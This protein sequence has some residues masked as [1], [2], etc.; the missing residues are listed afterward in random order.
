MADKFLLVP[1]TGGV[2]FRFVL[3]GQPSGYA[4]GLLS[5]HV[6]GDDA[7]TAELSCEHPDAGA[8][9]WAPTRTSLS[10]RGNL[11]PNT[12]LDGTAYGAVP[13]KYER[14]PY[15]WRLDIRHNALRLL[16]YLKQNIDWNAGNRWRIV[17]HSQGGLVLLAASRLCQTRDEFS[18]YVSRIALVACPLIGTLNAMG[19][20]IDGSSFGGLANAFLKKASRTWP[21][22]MQMFPQFG[23]VAAMPAMRATSADLWPGE[24]AGF[25][26]LLA[27]AKTFGQWYAQGPFSGLDGPIRL[28]LVFGCSAAPNTQIEVRSDPLRGPSMSSRMVTGDTLVPYEET[29]KY[30]HDQGLHGYADVVRGTTVPDHMM[31]LADSRVFSICAGFLDG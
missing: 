2:D 14:F 30:V 11:D 13:G 28:R 29:I 8:S 21:A 23:C 18:R 31:M 5:G 15:D 16:E 1:G 19:A 20:L 12:V 25:L 6:L 10:P 24:G 22:M 7:I 26:T 4:W 9:P 3:D 27:R 17:T